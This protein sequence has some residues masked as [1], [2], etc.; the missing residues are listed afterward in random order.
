MAEFF[1]T[2]VASGIVLYRG[3]SEDFSAISG[4]VISVAPLLN[5]S[6]M[7]LISALKP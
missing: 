7:P 3:D 6:N 1:Q 2:I 4:Q 5:N